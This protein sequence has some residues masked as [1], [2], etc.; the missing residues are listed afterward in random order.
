M[1][2]DDGNGSGGFYS[3]LAVRLV[4]SSSRASAILGGNPAPQDPV[5]L[6]EP[7]ESSSTVHAR[8]LRS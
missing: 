2:S 4:Y 5:I 8:Q 6:S 1:Q 3:S 7:E